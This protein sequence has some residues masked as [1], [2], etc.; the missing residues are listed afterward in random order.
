M[1][2]YKGRCP[3]C[4]LMLVT[5]DV[6]E[7]DHIIPKMDPGKDKFDNLQPLHRHYHD[8]KTARDNATRKVLEQETELEPIDA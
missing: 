2:K 6:I 3:E 7:V 1:K 4:G 8:V 5:D